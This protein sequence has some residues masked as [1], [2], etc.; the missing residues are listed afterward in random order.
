MLR[1]IACALCTAGALAG[2]GYYALCL[3]SIRSF[4]KE[5]L[6]GEPVT[7]QAVSVLKPL[8][9]MDPDLYESFRSHCLQDFGEYE[10]IFGVSDLEDASVP[11]VKR[12]QTEFPARDISL[13]VCPDAAA[14]N[15][16]AGN[17]AQM[18]RHARYDYILVNDSDIRVSR[19]YLRNIMGPFSSLEVGMV[20]AP[21]CAVP[22]ASLWSRIEAI[23]ISTDFICGVLAAR[24]L[25]GGIRFG[26]G[27]TLA[28]SRQALR[29]IGGFEALF[30]HLGDDY[31][32]G[33]RIAAADY[34]VVLSR[35]VVRT[36]LP[37][38]SVRGFVDHQLRWSRVIRDSRP[39]D[40][41]GL[42]ATF[43]LPWAILAT[44]FAGGSAWSLGVLGLVVVMRMTM[45]W[46][47]SQ[48]VL[49]DDFSRRNLW[50]VPLRDLIAML[51][52]FASFF[53]NTVVWRGERF[54][55]NHGKLSKL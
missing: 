14:T 24:Q 23:G 25:E 22:G 41:L 51:I 52:W 15:R 19:E 44:L 37:A 29:K 20:T 49:H 2:T 38:Y 8:K 55:L 7:S 13:V 3:Y 28:M 26:L 33:A 4:L 6:K 36:F 30:D 31:E 45:A 48:Y 53:G 9:G 10:I 5:R 21:Y 35:E 46:R 50:L 12:L 40:Y 34:K 32:L 42:A 17:L 27:S 43:G 18:L 11:Y 16:K 54:R 1:D 47:A 39:K